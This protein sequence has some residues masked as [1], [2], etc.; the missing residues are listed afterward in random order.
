MA[1]ELE[2][3]VTGMMCGGASMPSGSCPRRCAL[4]RLEGGHAAG[5]TSPRLRLSNEG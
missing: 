1:E 3:T 2:L 5:K 4:H